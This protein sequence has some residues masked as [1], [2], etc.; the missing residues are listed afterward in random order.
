[1]CQPQLLATAHGERRAE[2][3]ACVLQH[4]VHHVGGYFLSSTDQVAF[5][6]AVFIVNYDDKLS[7]PEILDGFIDSA[8]LIVYHNS[9]PLY[10]IIYYSHE[11]PRRP[12]SQRIPCS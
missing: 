5:I 8:E 10:L 4:E 6:F 1:M 7:I 11:Q 2:Q 9:F 12:V 3:S